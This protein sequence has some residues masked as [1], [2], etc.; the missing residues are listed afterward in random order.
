MAG[1]SLVDRGFKANAERLSERYRSELGLSKFAPL[2][3]FQLADHLKVPVFCVDDFTELPDEKLRRLQD[4]S[5]FSAMWMPNE[6]GDRIIIHNNHHSPKRQ[7]SN[8]MHE[9]AHIIQ[10]HEIPEE[11]AKLCLLY[12]L[13]YYN[14][15][16]EE[17]AKLL[18]ACLQITRPG[19]LWSLKR[20]LTED[21]I[22]EY[23]R[24]STD[25]VSFRLKTSG[26]LRQRSYQTQKSGG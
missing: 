20:N 10:G 9:L 11:A 15:K 6:D 13:H 17:E 26:V 12:G 18:G 7:Q 14:A 23:Y 25:M 16:Q 4:P 21:E 22:S 19:L 8:V 3:A 1:K 5:Q 24:A 2:D